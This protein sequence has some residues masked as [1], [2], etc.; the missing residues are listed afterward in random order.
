MRTP[1]PLEGLKHILPPIRPKRI[2]GWKRYAVELE[3]YVDYLGAREWHRI[4]ELDASHQYI[5][6]LARSIVT[7]L[8]PIANAWDKIG[9]RF[10]WEENK[11]PDNA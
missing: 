4:C 2:F 9:C 1:I 8:T 5:G 10:P 11:E 6:P 7:Q 3:R